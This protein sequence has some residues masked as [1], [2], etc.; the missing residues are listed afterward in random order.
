MNINLAQANHSF[1]ESGAGD[2]EEIPQG[3][4]PAVIL[5]HFRHD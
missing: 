2:V 4:K 3:L 1:G 5:H